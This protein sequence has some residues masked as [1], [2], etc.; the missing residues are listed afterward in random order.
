MHFFIKNNW[1]GSSSIYCVFLDLVMAKEGTDFWDV[2]EQ[3]G[4][5]RQN[6]FITTG[7]FL[8]WVLYNYFTV[9][10]AVNLLFEPFSTDATLFPWVLWSI[11]SLKAHINTEVTLMGLRYEFP[12]KSIWNWQNISSVGFGINI[13]WAKTKH[14]WRAKTNIL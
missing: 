6:T 5:N 3:F 1:E 14:P 2:T 4:S 12:S 7:C 13:T 10:I 11:L 9:L 8:L